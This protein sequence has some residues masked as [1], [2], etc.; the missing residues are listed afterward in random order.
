MMP[1]RRIASLHAVSLLMAERSDEGESLQQENLHHKN[2]KKAVNEAW[3]RV[4]PFEF[5]IS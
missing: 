4:L 1:N 5:L 2:Q 3:A